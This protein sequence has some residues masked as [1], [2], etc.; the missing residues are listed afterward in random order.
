LAS[1]GYLVH[2]LA[3]NCPPARASARASERF[4]VNPFGFVDPVSDPSAYTPVGSTGTVARDLAGYPGLSSWA[5]T[6]GA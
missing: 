6:G 5:A 2:G 3:V 4:A 1:A